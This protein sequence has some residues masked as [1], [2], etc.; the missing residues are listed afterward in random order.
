MIE[1]AIAEFEAQQFPGNLDQHE[2]R[3]TRIVELAAKRLA[4]SYNNTTAN[5]LKAALNDGINE[6]DDLAQLA[7]RVRQVYEFSNKVRA[8]AV[9][10]TEAFFVAN[11]GSREAYRQSGVVKSMRWYTA[12]DERTCE[13]CAPQN[14]KVIGV[15]ET[16]Y[17]KGYELE[18]ADGGVL[19]LDYRAIDVPPLHTNCRCFI[20]PEIISAT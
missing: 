10:R 7:E 12:E 13:F 11:E 5:L 4:R 9:A 6:G 20:R 17:P 2:P 15:N 16:F 3:I 19:K 1:Q 14:G 18:G 8:L